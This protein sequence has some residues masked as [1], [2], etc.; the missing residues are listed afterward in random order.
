[1]VSFEIANTGYCYNYLIFTMIDF[2]TNNLLDSLQLAFL[3]IFGLYL[4]NF[5]PTYFG[6]KAKNLATKED[7]GNITRIVESVK[8]EFTQET[9]KLKV[10]LHF[11]SQNRMSYSV[12]KRNAIL[13]FYKNYCAWLQ[14]MLGSIELSIKTPEEVFK[15]RMSIEESY[16][17][18]QISQTLFELYIDDED[19]GSKR[20][21]LILDTLHFHNERVKYLLL[22]EHQYNYQKLAEEMTL[23]MRSQELNK[24]HLEIMRLTE[25]FNKEK[26]KRYKDVFQKLVEFRKAIKSELYNTEHNQNQTSSMN[27]TL[28]VPKSVSTEEYLDL[29]EMNKIRAEIENAQSE[30]DNKKGEDDIVTVPIITTS[31]T[32]AI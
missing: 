16:T 15:L 4:K 11:L 25:D 31:P 30:F 28:E 1:M 13:D 29:Q 19:L 23:E 9:E 22:I 12:D 17:K 7:I 6:E 10:D 8:T 32:S 26:I 21:K 3:I 2:I 24:I 20:S 27:K 18:V 5:L 14:L